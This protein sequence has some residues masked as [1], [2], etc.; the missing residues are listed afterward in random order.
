MGPTVELVARNDLDPAL[1]DLLIA[2]AREV[3]G[4]AGMF[5]N[6]GEYPA[7][8]A[9]DFPISPDAERYYK[10]GTQFLYK[11]LPFWLAKLFA[12]LVVV[13]LP[14]LVILIPATRLVPAAYKWLMRSRIIKWYGAMMNIER[15]MLARPPA[16][17]QYMLLRRFEAIEK[18]VNEMK[19]PA[20]FGDQLYVL[21]D[22]VRLVRDRL[23]AMAQSMDKS[24]DVGQPPVA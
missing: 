23:V 18:A 13:V 5:R 19:A 4:G 3:H 17:E 11:T 8:L 22:H 12:R 10:S 16:D 6:A 15:A 24:R 2:A 1:S 14:L 21:R 20:S 9:R 7:P